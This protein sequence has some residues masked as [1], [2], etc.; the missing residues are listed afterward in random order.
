MIRETDLVFR[1]MHYGVIVDYNRQFIYK[2]TTY[3]L[4]KSLWSGPVDESSVLGSPDNF[5]LPVRI[6]DLRLG[7]H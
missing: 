5:G 4:F 7:V 3:Q 6:E 1:Q 2:F